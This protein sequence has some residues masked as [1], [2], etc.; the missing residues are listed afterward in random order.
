MVD[1]ID[2]HRDQFGVEPISATSPSQINP[3]CDTRPLSSPV[4]V[5]GRNGL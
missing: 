3:A 2:R 1:Y 4:T 5:R